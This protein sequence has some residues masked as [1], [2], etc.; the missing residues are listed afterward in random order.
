[1]PLLFSRKNSLH[2]IGSS[3]GETHSL[4]VVGPALL[5]AALAPGLAGCNDAA[6]SQTAPP[7]RPVQVQRV[8]FVGASEEREFAGVVRARYETDLGFRVAGKMIARLVNNGDRVRAGDVVARLDPRDL[9]LQVESAEAEV[10]AATSNLAQAAAD[11]VRYQNLRKTGFAALADYERKKAA[12][13]E[14]EGRMERAQRALDLARNQLAY[15]DLKA[16]ADGVITATL[17]EAGQVVALGQ[18]VA[19]LAHRGEMEAA[20]ALPE[21]R[22]NE[23]REAKASVRLWSGPD[24]RFAAHLRELS[25]QAD[26]A[27]RTYAA[28]F[29]IENPDDT[30]A[31]GMTATVVL[32]HPTETKVAR[33][34]LAAILNRGAG[35]TVFRVDDGGLLERRPVTVSSFNEVAALVTSGL[36][37]GDEI[38]TLGVQMLEAGQK[39][40]AIMGH[41]IGE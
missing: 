35:P 9:Q 6:V 34:P 41:V 30:V 21:T 2:P 39:V 37:D 10:S 26:P 36:Q 7:P 11:E 31:L 4:G 16:D 19:R 28:R 22:L 1:M 29:T 12:R 27:T 18:A 38:V 17:A 33:V 24:R 20:V 25:P 23:A 15:A 32:S 8:T 40:R 3:R 14:A 13:D 5:L